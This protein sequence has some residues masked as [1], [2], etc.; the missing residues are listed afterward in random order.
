MD[1]FIMS[2][3][4]KRLEDYF[5]KNYNAVQKD[6][7]SKRFENLSEE[8]FEELMDLS[9]E[10]CI[11]LPKVVDF[12]KL[13]EKLKPVEQKEEVKF[14]EVECPLCKSSGLIEQFHTINGIE[15]GGF[16]ALCGCKNAERWKTQKGIAPFEKTK[17]YREYQERNNKQKVEL[18]LKMKELEEG[19]PINLINETF[20][21]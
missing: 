13:K 14:E 21:F 5:E 1:Y 18:N 9:I 10:N 20:G 15:Y 17:C 16:Y 3:R 6:E 8:Q 4:L 2:Q 11:Y 12:C 7:I 19:I